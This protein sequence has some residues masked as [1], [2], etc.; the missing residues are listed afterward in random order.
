MVPVV[1]QSRQF[2]C[3][4]V[5]QVI[6]WQV[7]NMVQWTPDGEVL[8]HWQRSH[9]IDQHARLVHCQEDAL[10]IEDSFSDAVV[11]RYPPQQLL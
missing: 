2:E 8:Q 9:N 11:L 4:Q 7:L 1:L 5:G 3:G 6:R 10:E